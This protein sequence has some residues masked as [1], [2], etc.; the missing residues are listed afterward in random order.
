MKTTASY[1]R[2]FCCLAVLLFVASVST[3]MFAASAKQKPQGGSD[4]Q[5]QALLRRKRCLRPR[6]ET[7]GRY[8]AF[9]DLRPHAEG[10]T[11][12]DQT[13]KGRSEYAGAA[14][15]PDAEVEP[16]AGS[17]E[18][19]K[20]ID[21]QQDKRTANYHQWATPEQFGQ[22]FGVHDN[23][24]AK[25]TAWMQSHGLKVENVCQVEAA[26]SQ[27]SGT[28][29]QLEKAFQMEMHYYLMPNGETHVSNDRDISVPQALRPVISG[30]PTL[31]DFFKKG[32]HNPRQS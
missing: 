4:C 24:I 2:I 15:D 25:V 31:N 18:A 13:G 6:H 17:G 26:R 32:H 29:G 20:V 30:V 14:F 3:E 16:G 5:I 27:F 10:A 9:G 21:E 23:D 22:H 7:C 12:R 11:P 1:M 8:E 19:R 28:S